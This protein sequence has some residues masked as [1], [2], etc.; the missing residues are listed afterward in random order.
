MPELP[1]VETILRS[2][3]KKLLGR[4]IEGVDVF[5]GEVIRQ[6]KPE[7]FAEQLSHKTIIDMERRGKYLIFKLSGSF[8]LLVH[9]RMTGKLLFVSSDTPRDEYVRVAFRLNG[10]NELR[11]HDVRRL[12]TLDL[13]PSDGLDELECLKALGPDALDPSLTMDVFERRLKRKR[14]QV[15]RVLLDQTFVAGIGNIY[16]N[17]I[18]WKACIRPERA[19]SSLTPREAER[20][21]RAMRQVLLSA[22]E[23]RG[24]TIRDYV[25]GEGIPGSY[26]ELLVV[27][28]R[29]GHPCP[30]CGN[31]IVRSK[32]G[33]R[34]TYFC[35]FCQR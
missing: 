4:T 2:L 23:H 35:P 12:G 6:P 3:K 21:Y 32:N 14:G 5:S 31:L 25:D 10:R 28:G 11:F 30:V 34:S 29:E 26:Q 1:E 16:A 22:V 8:A 7:Q 13:V 18:L 15:K 24:T 19:V 33:G 17:E 9:L 20:L 27:H